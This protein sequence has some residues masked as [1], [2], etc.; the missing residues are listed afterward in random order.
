MGMTGMCRFPGATHPKDKHSVS[1]QTPIRPL[2][3]QNLWTRMKTQHPPLFGIPHGHPQ[4]SLFGFTIIISP[5]NNRRAYLRKDQNLSFTL[6]PFRNIKNMLFRFAM[7]F[8]WKKC[9]PCHIGK[10]DH[11]RPLD[12]N[13]NGT[14]WWKFIIISHGSIYPYNRRQF[15]VLFKR[16]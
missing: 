1:S 16:T 8:D 10:T 13:K 11:L 15:D 5:Q 3:L 9:R 4:E 2:R 12:G 6:L 7:R 14:I